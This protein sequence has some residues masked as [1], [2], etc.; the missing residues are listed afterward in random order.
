MIS[1]IHR[2]I[3]PIFSSDIILIA[4]TGAQPFDYIV[5]PRSQ[6]LKQCLK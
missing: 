6:I 1:A 5:V 4:I 3:K 2:A